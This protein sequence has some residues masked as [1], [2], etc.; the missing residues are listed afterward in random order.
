M[1]LYSPVGSFGHRLD[2]CER[3]LDEWLVWLG[4]NNKGS[5]LQAAGVAGTTAFKKQL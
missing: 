5:A 3:I 2:R 4:R 1:P